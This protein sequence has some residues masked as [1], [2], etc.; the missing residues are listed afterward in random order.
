MVAGKAKHSKMVSPAEGTFPVLGHVDGILVA[1]KG[2]D[3][4]AVSQSGPRGTRSYRYYSY[5]TR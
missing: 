4:R 1:K 2:G 5:Q 3:R